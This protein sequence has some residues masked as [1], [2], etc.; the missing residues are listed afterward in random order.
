MS[1]PRSW[2]ATR[3]LALVCCV[4]LLAACA[5][6][7]APVPGQAHWSGRL[8]VQVDS[9]PPQAFSAG[10]NLS[11]SPDAGELALTAPARRVHWQ[12]EDGMQVDA[13]PVL[14]RVVML[15]LLGNAWKYTGQVVDARVTLT[16]HTASDGTVQCCV[17]DNGAG[18]DMKYASQLFEPFKRLH[19]HHE[20]EGT[21][22]GLATVHRVVERHGG[23]VWG[24]G[25]VGQGATFCFSLPAPAAPTE[26]AGPL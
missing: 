10:F 6:P 1:F 11:G 23:R 14:M 9:T 22:V 20:F 24:E 8:A 2:I 12:I 17:R 26:A 21:G 7:R 4:G 16:R 5:T 13:D 15:N 19:A 3:R 18:F 25:A